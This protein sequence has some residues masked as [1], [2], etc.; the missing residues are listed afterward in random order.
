MNRYGIVAA[1]VLSMIAAAAHAQ[2]SGPL[3]VM[4]LLSPKERK[5]V[6]PD[7][8]KINAAALGTRDNPVRTYMPDGERAYLMRLVCPDGSQPGFRRRG[9]IGAGPYTTILDLYDVTCG[10]TSREVVM[11]M[12]HPA[13]V[14]RRA[15]AGFKIRP[16]Q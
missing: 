9:S 8:K 12:Y 4:D 5:Q 10:A 2:T 11:D 14:E 1:I 15:V 3:E 16:P 13:Y 6:T 7:W